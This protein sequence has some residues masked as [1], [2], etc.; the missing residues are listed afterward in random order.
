MQYICTMEYY[1]AIK[2]DEIMPFVATRMNLA[3]VILSEGSQTK[4]KQYCITSFICGIWKEMKEI[5]LLNR[6]GLT[7]LEDELIVACTHY[8]I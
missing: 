3:I 5:N 1:S 8:Y 2:N 4:K 7:D 6:K